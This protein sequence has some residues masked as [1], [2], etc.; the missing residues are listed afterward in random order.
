MTDWP[1]VSV[2]ITAYNEE[3]YIAEA[4]ESVL[5]QT[6][7]NVEIVVVDD[8]STD[9][10]G[11]VVK[12]YGDAVQYV[13]KENGGS[14][15]A[16]NRGIRE[17]QGA[18]VA[19]L[20]ADDLWRPT[21][22]EIQMQ[23]HA[24]D[25]TLAWSYTDSYLVGASDETILYRRS[26]VQS[27]PDG[28]VLA[29]L[30]L[31]NFIAPS[32]TVVR[33]DVLEAV[34][35]FDETPLHRISEDWD[36]WLRIAEQHRVRFINVPLTCM[37]QHPS[38][39]TTSMDLE[40]ALESRMAIIDKAV[41]RNPQQLADVH[42]TARANLL[43]NIGRKWIN[44]E[45]RHKARELLKLAIKRMPTCWRAWIYGFATVLPRPLLRVLGRVRARYRRSNK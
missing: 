13:W 31:G 24:A 1:L 29:D 8:G 4:L 3:E 32:M 26:Q 19:F 28:E 36:L 21:K 9:A 30:L 16:R 12:A 20:D 7:R 17:S 23:Q 43:V 6:Y 18:Y 39:K 35:G 2:V 14:A 40:H 27:C 42:D 37:R 34:G 15:S 38:R 10:T 45:E 44:R 25:P 11:E 5:E 22:L 41:E 33:S